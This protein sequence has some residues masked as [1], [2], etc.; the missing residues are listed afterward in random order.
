MPLRSFPLR[1][2][3]ARQG[4]NR[5]G[6]CVVLTS[7]L[8]TGGL[9]IAAALP[10]GNQANAQAASA[11][12]GEAGKQEVLS[13]E[14]GRHLQQAQAALK[15]RHYEKAMAAVNAA[16]EVKGK[17]GYDSYVIAQMAAAVAAQAGRPDVTIRAYDALMANPR[18]TH[19]EKAQML[20]AE[21]SLAYKA[22]DYAATE[23][24]ASR[25]LREIGP[26][27][28]MEALLVQCPYL[29]KNWPA[30]VKAARGVI[31]A[32]QK[33]G[34]RPP[35]NVLQMLAAASGALHDQKGQTDA[36]VA[37]VK[38]YPRPQYWQNVIHTLVT[39]KTLSPRLVF[40]LQRLRLATGVLTDPA[41]FQD[42]AERAVQ[43]G[44][45]KLG[46]DLL[47]IG[48]A[49]H[50]LGTGPQ[51]PAQARFRAF[52][53]QQADKTRA[54]LPEAV[55][56]AR[57]DDAAGPALTAGANLVLTGQVDEGLALMRTGL[58]RKPRFPAIAQLEYG[59]AEMDG[60]RPRDALRVFT[61]LSQPESAPKTKAGQAPT[62][63]ENAERGSVS[64]LAQLW[65]L[66][67]QTSQTAKTPE[68]TPKAGSAK[69]T[70]PTRHGQAQHERHK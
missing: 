34:A 69:Q 61:A 15:S 17:T 30:T 67:L 35:E 28:T 57:E 42:M 36:Y 24:A 33:K 52:I 7:G 49:R 9:L 29:Q 43:I 37:L 13:A 64:S 41:D 32:Q 40:N 5:P 20:Q 56:A 59:M 6:A 45:P 46:L 44:L 8:L 62:A 60:G 27:A 31:A 48:Y 53:A 18:T 65:T 47:D 3:M 51:A 16:Q 1:S 58:A 68:T 63:Q 4:K 70:T 14:V 21:A 12:G 19:A 38:Y 26:N 50:L 54:A 2:P 11:S 55:K 22:K 25:Y 10:L 66:V 23:K 39:D